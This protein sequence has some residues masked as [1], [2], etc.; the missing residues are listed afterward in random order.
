[1]IIAIAAIIRPT[2]TYQPAEHNDATITG[3]GGNGDRSSITMKTE[4]E[5]ET[6]AACVLVRKPAEI[7]AVMSVSARGDI[8]QRQLLLGH[9]TFATRYGLRYGTR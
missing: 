5:S 4:S 9:A 7:G 8:H 6:R 1:V 3:T 2:C